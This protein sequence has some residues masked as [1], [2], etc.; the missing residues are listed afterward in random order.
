MCAKLEFPRVTA[1]TF[2]S[3]SKLGIGI[4]LLFG[5]SVLFLSIFSCDYFYE[6]KH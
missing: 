1:S 2:R 6:T 3:F 5:F 4:S